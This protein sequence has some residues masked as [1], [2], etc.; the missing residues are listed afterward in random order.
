MA[1]RGKLIVLGKLIDPATILKEF[2]SESDDIELLAVIEE[3]LQAIK[4]EQGEDG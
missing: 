3:E 1:L 4:E 2:G